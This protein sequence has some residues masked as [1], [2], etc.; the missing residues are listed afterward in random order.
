MMAMLDLALAAAVLAV[1]VWTLRV[2]SN[3]SAV[4]G[5]VAFGLLLALVWVDRKSVV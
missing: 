5:F 4:L 2:R 1:S 3:F